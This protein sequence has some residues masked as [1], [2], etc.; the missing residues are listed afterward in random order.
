MVTDNEIWS[1]FMFICVT[2][3]IVHFFGDSITLFCEV[4]DI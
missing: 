2:A 3:D 1:N 4:V